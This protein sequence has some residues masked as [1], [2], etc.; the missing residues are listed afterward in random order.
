MADPTPPALWWSASRG[1][2]ISER[3]HR[4]GYHVVAVDEIE[5]RLPADAVRLVP[6]SDVQ[7][8]LDDGERMLAQH[9]TDVAEIDRLRAGLR[10]RPAPAAG[11]AREPVYLAADVWQALHLPVEEF[12][13]YYERNGWGETWAVLMAAVRGPAKCGRPVDGEVCVLAP[14][15]ES[16][17]CYGASDVG[18]SEPLPSPATV[19]APDATPCRN[20]AVAAWLKRSRDTHDRDDAQWWVIDQLLDDYRTHADYGTPLDRE[21]HEPPHASA[22]DCPDGSCSG[23]APDTGQAPDVAA[24]APGILHM[25]MRY[26]LGRATYAVWEVCDAIK[27]H[28]AELA[29]GTRERMAQ[30]IVE[31]LRYGRGGMDM[32]IARWADARRVLLGTDTTPEET[33]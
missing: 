16:A 21:V 14:H 22:V 24:S 9:A 12:D 26:A 27:A 19:Q 28:A 32:D 18:S 15:S 6:E 30:E 3:P 33:D 7:F 29:P 11:Q 5:P 25:A 20:D 4:D 17:P 23:A 8:L 2:L 13:G 31:A 10:A 1:W